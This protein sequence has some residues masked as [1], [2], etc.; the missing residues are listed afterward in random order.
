MYDRE[1]VQA[2]SDDKFEGDRIG[3]ETKANFAKRDGRKMNEFCDRMTK[4]MWQDYICN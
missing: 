2:E 4:K 3:M 1:Q